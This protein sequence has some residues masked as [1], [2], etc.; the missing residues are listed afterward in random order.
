[1]FVFIPPP[2]SGPTIGDVVDAFD[3][4]NITDCIA[5]IISLILGWLTALIILINVCFGRHGIYIVSFIIG[6]FIGILYFMVYELIIKPIFKR[7][8]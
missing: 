2:G 8:S 4:L 6:N 3:S 7:K 5:L 1:M